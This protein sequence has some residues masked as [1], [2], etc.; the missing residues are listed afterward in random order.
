MRAPC[1]T[2]FSTDLPTSCLPVAHAPLYI[3]PGAERGALLARGPQAG[4]ARR[5]RRVRRREH[6]DALRGVPPAQDGRGGAG[7]A[8]GEAAERSEVWRGGVRRGPRRGRKQGPGTCATK[9][10]ILVPRLSPQ[11]YDPPIR[12]LLGTGGSTSLFLAGPRHGRRTKVLGVDRL[13]EANVAH[14]KP[15]GFSSPSRAFSEP[16]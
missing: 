1:H 15:R 7:A 13:G 8:R 9:M 16:A 6:A 4:G 12:R 10:M 3:T 5:R 11:T 2:P 14:T